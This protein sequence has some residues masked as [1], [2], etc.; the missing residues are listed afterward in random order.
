METDK[1]TSELLSK[2]ATWLHV[3]LDSY[4]LLES[5]VDRK[6]AGSFHSNTKCMNFG[7]MVGFATRLISTAI[8]I[9]LLFDERKWLSYCLLTVFFFCRFYSHIRFVS[10]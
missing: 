4:V 7:F 2:L 5:K 1:V 10:P 8:D 9:L 3:K 6:M